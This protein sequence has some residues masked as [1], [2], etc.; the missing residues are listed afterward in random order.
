M[1]VDRGELCASPG[2]CHT[3]NRVA[4]RGTACAITT[5]AMHQDATAIGG[6]DHRVGHV[7]PRR[8][9]AASSHAPV[10]K[11]CGA[12]ASHRGRWGGRRHDQGLSPLQRPLRALT[13]CAQRA[14]R[15]YGRKRQGQEGLYTSTN[16]CGRKVG[17]YTCHWRVRDGY[18]TVPMM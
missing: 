15:V 13:T 8:M 4:L 12:F 7:W 17:S 11:C 1:R 14:S 6:F 18:I 10:L 16:L 3:G 9:T 2:A 5:R